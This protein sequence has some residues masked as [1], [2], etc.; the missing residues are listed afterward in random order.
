MMR[1]NGWNGNY[2]CSPMGNNVFGGWHY[3]I[4]LG[5][6]II[7]IALLSFARRKNNSNDNQAI[8]RLK[9]LYVKGEITEEEYL[10]R[11]NV[12]ERH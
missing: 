12:I 9:E 11:K 6:V 2:G 4:M 8:I 7:I 3:L 5:V 10:K 1:G